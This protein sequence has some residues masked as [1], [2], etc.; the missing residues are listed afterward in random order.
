MTREPK[1][2]RKTLSEAELAIAAE[3][4]DFFARAAAAELELA[5]TKEEQWVETTPEVIAKLNRNGLGG[6]KYFIYKGVKVCEYGKVEEIIAE[7]DTPVSDRVM[8]VAQAKIEGRTDRR[9]VRVT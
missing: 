4:E 8:G 7:E 2:K 5:T 1:L 3:L 9:I 6:A